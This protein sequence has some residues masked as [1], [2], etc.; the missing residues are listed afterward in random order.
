MK[1]LSL[2]KYGLC[3]VLTAFTSTTVC[4]EYYVVYSAPPQPVYITPTTVVASPCRTS[5]R[6]VHHYKKRYYSVKSSCYRRRT[7]SP[8]SCQLSVYYAV[9]TCNTCNPCGGNCNTTWTQGGPVLG[10]DFM[11][12]YGPPV[13]RADTYHANS[14]YSWDNRTGD[15]SEW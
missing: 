11:V 5:C 13:Y 12:T 7:Y 6:P 2:V 3:S 1:Y 8:Q 10:T 4:A 15:D 14:E 9:P